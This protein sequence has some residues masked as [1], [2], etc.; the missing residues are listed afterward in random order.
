MDKTKYHTIWYFEN[1]GFTQGVWGLIEAT[2]HMAYLFY[3]DIYLTL[4]FPYILWKITL[5]NLSV[6]YLMTDWKFWN[7][8][9]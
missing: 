1:P 8:N 2:E 7:R 4:N 9:K 6:V 5:K 3:V